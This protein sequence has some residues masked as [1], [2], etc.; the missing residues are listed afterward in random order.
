M[1]IEPGFSRER[2]DY[3]DL[4]AEESGQARRR[5][6]IIIG[7]GLVVLLVAAFF[8]LRGS[9]K[10]SGKEETTLPRVTV[11]VPGREPV[12]SIVSATGTLAARREMPVGVVGE[13]GRVISVPV[14]AGQ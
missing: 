12:T 5:R 8:L 3:M 4:P 14:E 2:T 11:I 10:D 7:A 9:G 13:G 1:N 6:W